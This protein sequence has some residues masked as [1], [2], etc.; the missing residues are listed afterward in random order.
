MRTVVCKKLLSDWKIKH[1]TIR[2][3]RW[4]MVRWCTEQHT[5]HVVLHL[6]LTAPLHS[7]VQKTWCTFCN[8]HTAYNPSSS[9]WLNDDDDDLRWYVPFFRREVKQSFCRWTRDDPSAFSIQIWIECRWPFSHPS[10]K[11]NCD[12]IGSK[13]GAKNLVFFGLQTELEH[14]IPFMLLRER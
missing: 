12:E 8:S 6:Q 5:F 13:W 1:N 9:D 4:T 3:W 11:G 10:W 7:Q 14:L 2:R